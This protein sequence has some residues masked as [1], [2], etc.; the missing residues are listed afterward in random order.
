MEAIFTAI[1]MHGKLNFF[2]LY[3]LERYCIQNE[4]IEIH[5]QM[6]HAAKLSEKMKMYKFLFGPV[7]D[8]AVR[9]FTRQGWEGMDKVKA[10][11]KLQAEFAK[12]EMY[13]SKTGQVE[14]YLID[15]SSMS[16]ARLLKFI[17]DCLLF[18]ETELETEVPD[19]EE[20]KAGRI[21]GRS[22]KK[23]K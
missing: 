19:S 14:I 12:E 16:K 7:M 11:Y 15:L 10:R 2:N 23:V 4:G 9:G 6:K 18:I 22:Y 13:N 3:D 5:V 21:S 17:Q 1:P 20:Y 8:S